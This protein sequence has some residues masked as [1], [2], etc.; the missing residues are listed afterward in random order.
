VNSV[1]VD[2]TDLNW[3][4][5]FTGLDY[6]TPPKWCERPFPSLLSVGE[7]LIFYTPLLN[8]LP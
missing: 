3:E 6:W 1:S 7:W 5:L 2:I 4:S 8:L